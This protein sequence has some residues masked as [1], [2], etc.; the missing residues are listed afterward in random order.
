L[1]KEFDREWQTLS[2][3]I[4]TGMKEWRLQ[5]PRATLKEM[6]EALHERM[7][8]LEARMLQ[9]MALASKAAD[10]SEVSVEERPVCPQCGARLGRRGKRER[11]LQTQGGA[12]VVLERDYVVCPSCKRGFF[13]P[14]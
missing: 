13:P 6:E 5:H 10:L 8:R 3:E 2:E 7:A 4:L 9:D 12:E 1:G 14:G 11:H